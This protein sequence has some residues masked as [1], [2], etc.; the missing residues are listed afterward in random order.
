[1]PTSAI[2]ANGVDIVAPPDDLPARILAC[3]AQ[4]P[5]LGIP[6]EHQVEPEPK[7]VDYPARHQQM[8][9]HHETI[10]QWI[11]ADKA[12]GGNLYTHL[13]I[14]SRPYSKRSGSYDRR[15][16]IKNRVD[17]DDRPAVVERRSRIGDRADLPAAA[18]VAGTSALKERVHTFIST[19][20]CDSAQ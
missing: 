18:A 20:G 17:I 10:Y 15:G 13:R 1:M 19:S 2:A 6:D 7:A 3:L 4:T 9:L 16:K 11:Y 8:D 12:E 5:A 14:V